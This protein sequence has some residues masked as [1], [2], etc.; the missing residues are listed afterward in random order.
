MGIFFAAFSLLNILGVPVCVKLWQPEELINLF[1][2]VISSQILIVLACESK[3]QALL[4]CR[5]QGTWINVASVN[6]PRRL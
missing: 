4:F 5:R 2:F 6:F 3:V 1:L